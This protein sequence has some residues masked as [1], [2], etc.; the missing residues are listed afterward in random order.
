MSDDRAIGP[1]ILVEKLGEGGMGEVWRAEQRAPIHRTVALKI[2]KAGMDTRRI[3]ARFEAER[4]ALARMD[5]P[6]IARV[7]D[8][9]ETPR[10]LPYFAMEHV[11]GEPIHLYCERRKLG[12]RE[13][14][15]LFVA[16]CEGVQHA[17]QKGIVHRDLKPSNVLVTEVDGKAMPKIIDFGV[18]KAIGEPLTER[19]LW[20]E[21]GALIGTPEYMSPE[22][23]SLELDVDTRSD[24]YS[25]GVMLYELLTGV[26]PFDSKTL[27]AGSLDEIRRTIA[28]VEPARP[29]V[30]GENRRLA[31]DLDWIVMKALEKERGRRYGS[32]GE[33]A[34]DLERHL[35]D[36]PVLASPP[37]AL[38]RARKF[39]RRHTIAVGIAVAVVLF[40]AAFSVA[41]AAQARRIVRQ[42]DRAQNASEFLVRL[43]QI[44]DPGEERG[45]S[46]TAREI[47]DRG[48]EI[49][50][51][52]LGG[53]PELQMQIMLSMGDLYIMLGLP[54]KAEP[55]IRR[56]LETCT[57]LHG[58]DDLQ[59]LHYM[60]RMDA[61]YMRSGRFE[62][63]AELAER[64]LEGRRRILG[65]DH[66]DTLVSMGNLAF[67]YGAYGVYDKSEALGKEILERRRRLFGP[68][69]QDTLWAMNDLGVLY[70]SQR[71]NREA[72]QILRRAVEAEER[73]GLDPPAPF[74]GNFADSLIA[75][76]RYEEGEALLLKEQE[77]I[78]HLFGAE[79]P[80]YIESRKYLAVSYHRHGRTAD[81]ERI[82]RETIEVVTR[83]HDE[84]AA[85]SEWRELA[86]IQRDTGRY[87]E[88][89]R[90]LKRVLARWRGTLR[91]GHHEITATMRE[92]ARTYAAEGRLRE[93][94]RQ[95]AESL[96]ECRSAA[97]GR[98]P[99]AGEASFE[100]AGLAALSGNRELALE[101]L[102]RAVEAGFRDADRMELDPGLRSLRGDPDFLSIVASAR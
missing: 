15:L 55:L 63:G 51:R 43:F 31:G 69:D 38:Y 17:H 54:L 8:A 60:S 12:I 44:A 2:L 45:R 79:H 59:T 13:R 41:T 40:L 25:L 7:F 30:A 36:E 22:Q 82:L 91:P 16:V 70:L 94:E 83:T 71:R 73:L 92:L 47:F 62:Q 5:H 11:A 66:R 72:E 37:G 35:A 102:R 88:A 98:C 68:D 58:P 64:V 29:S 97:G 85:L 21:L 61:V 81:A 65:P 56:A 26:L 76:G 75:L 10:G 93:A 20:T 50:D 23:T 89:E 42:R 24:V 1:Y 95:H 101:R 74:F 32:P 19:T 80:E 86:I 34:A 52:D 48:A 18:A 4:Q 46:I 3:V 67:W 100:L 39:A 27:R 33:L 77:T 28:E 96:A 9:G 6:A 90:T 99:E 14:L 53:E 87:D 49:I 78:Q 84:D 57:R